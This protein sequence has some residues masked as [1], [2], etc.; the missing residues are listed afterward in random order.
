MDI[1]MLSGDEAVA[2]GAW[3]A[4]A[5][6]GVAYPGTPS[7][8]ILENLAL[9]KDDVYVQWACNEKVA[10]E[11]AAGAAVGG[12]RSI[13]SMKH[14]GLN[15]AAD[16]MFTLAY[17]GVNAGCVIVTADDPG[18][19]SSQ[20]EQD[21]RWYA[22]HAKLIM[23]EPSDSQEC[24]DFTKAAFE[25]SEKY[26][27]PVLLRMTTR[28]CHSK[29]LVN[30][31]EREGTVVKTYEGN[32][33]KYAMLPVNARKR[34]EYVESNFK[35]LVEVSDNSPF[36]RIEWAE[37]KTVGVIAS[38]ISYMHAREAFGEGVSF[39]K[40]GMTNPMPKGLISE[41]C[42]GVEKVYIVEEGDGFIEN[43]VRALGF[44]C[45]GKEVISE[46][47]E[48]DPQRIRQ[49]FSL[50]E[51]PETYSVEA[52]VPARPP[53]LC[54]GCPHRGFYFSVRKHRK[55]IAPI[56]DIGC[57]SLGC[58]APFNG[59]EMAICMGAG[60]SATIGLAR[61]L[62]AQGDSRKVLGMMGDSTF[63]HSG[64]T[65]LID[66]VHS[67]ANVILCLLDNSITAMTGH[68]DNPGTETNLMGQ[69]V[70][71]IDALDIIRASGIAEDR[72]MVVDPIDQKQI[73]KALEAAVAVE[74]PFVIICRRPCALLKPVMKANAGKHCVVNTDKCVGCGQCIKV[75]C[76]SLSF[77]DGKA[78]V[79]DPDGCNACGLCAQQCKFDA[80]ERIGE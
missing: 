59:F 77:E 79:S 50:G 47:G 73:D 7:T 68:Q 45:L 70:P 13:V 52:S 41:F 4:G 1:H 42:K 49:A 22:L 36:N 23:L 51:L 30:F 64:I 75:A 15:V 14:V 6:V 2:R 19:H 63:F 10:M 44:D 20:N 11:I 72:V 69:S 48:L 67:N 78:K 28:V 12:V 74:G 16:P 21:N 29:T 60:W 66:V 24:K 43:A 9:Y 35:R 17:T 32:T 18:A 5:G 61:A 25:M 27:V 40:L 65:G 34:H 71:A 39:L 57:Y 54:A 37:D 62:K 8:E 33:A 56:G 3:E 26:D 46:Q 38:G 58:S 31:E 53:V 55:L 76:P 80:I